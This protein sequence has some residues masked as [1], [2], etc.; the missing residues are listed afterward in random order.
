MDKKDNI[1]I[2]LTHSG[3]VVSEIIKVYTRREYSHIYIS[4]DEELNEMYSFGRIHSYFILPGG[5]VIDNFESKF[6]NRFENT[7]YSVYKIGISEEQ[8]LK[9]ENELMEMKQNRRKYGYNILGVITA[10]IGLPLEREDKY[11]CSQFVAGVLDK[12][13]IDIVDKPYGLVRPMDFV[14]SGKMKFVKEGKIKK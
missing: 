14:D 11:F 8:R 3:T 5:L 6:Y 10:T 13:G 12:S 1:Y 9:L 4:L 7:T 2:V